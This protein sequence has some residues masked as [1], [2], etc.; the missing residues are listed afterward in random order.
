MEPFNQLI[1]IIHIIA[2]GIS[3][4][5]G[6]IAMLNQTG[7]KL[8]RISGKTFFYAMT[9]IFVSAIYL[10]IIHNLLF[11]FLIAIFSYYNIAVAYRA[12]YLKK[13]GKGQKPRI[14]DWSIT[15]IT[16]LFHA[17]LII[18]GI[19][20][21]FVDG[22]SFGIVALIFGTIGGLM[23]LR[24]YNHFNKGYKEKNG[25]LFV[26]ISGMIG[27]YI[28]AVT[29]FLVNVVSFQPSFVLWLAPTVLLVPF[30]IYTMKKFRRKF[31]KGTSVEN[32]VSLKI[33]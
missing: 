30:M 2:G 12:L 29:A 26:H 14:L 18:W 27:G 28:A 1:L 19:K 9:V 10:S 31:N 32:I 5:S 24:D 20:T 7:N 17:A 25:W 4:V 22:Q 8:H 13:L 23:N 21:V 11:L 16:T 33:D 6:P 3:L 15:I